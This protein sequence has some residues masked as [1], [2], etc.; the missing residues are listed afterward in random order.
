[1][2]RRKMKRGQKVILTSSAFDTHAGPVTLFSGEHIDLL[3]TYTVGFAEKN[4]TI[5]IWS[6]R[7]PIGL[8]L[9]EAHLIPIGRHES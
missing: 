7:L 6:D 8:S 9:N 4:G 1:M 3:D 2:K 5:T